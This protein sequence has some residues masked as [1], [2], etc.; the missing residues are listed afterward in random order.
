[1]N[2]SHCRICSGKLFSEPLLHYENMPKAAQFLPDAKSLKNDKGTDLDI[3]QCSGCGLVQLNND[4]VP[5]YK[6]VIRSASF[7]EEMMKFRIQQFTGFIQ[8]YSLKGKKIIEIGCGKGE[9]LSL[10]NQCSMKCF[11]LENYRQ[12][13]IECKN[14]GLTVSQGFIQNDTD[15]LRSSPFDSFYILNFLE[16]LPNPN[17]TLKGIRNN[18]TDDS[19][20]LI[21]VPNFDMILQKNLFS[22]FTA[23]H[24]FY[25]T[26]ETL[27]KTLELNGFDLLE[28]NVVWHD[29]IISAVVKKSKTMYR[30]D[31]RR[32]RYVGK[33]LDLSYFYKYQRKII[34]EID[35]Y[36]G[37]YKK[38][39]IWGAGH[40][41]LTII[42]MLNL[43]SKI[44]YVVDSALFKQN[45]YTPATHIP[46]VSPDI[47]NSDSV[48][49]IIIMAA[50][51]SDE[52]VGTIRQKY[53]RNIKL[54]ILR[55]FGLEEI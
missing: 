24:L 32:N 13:V 26:K 42:S 48:D 54:S 28:S 3:C 36:I 31:E 52:I 37:K 14:K 19:I 6:D 4:P 12:S 43:S 30:S 7:S 23:D 41:A 46:I 2:I 15:K 44:K 11:G 17:K 33:K 22:E 16:H 1:M 29:Y 27:K 51:Y 21:E 9:Y 35:N 5:H 55:D 40:Q 47:I 8:K 38:V 45:K 18:I 10:M 53:D 20:G 50:G 25:F 39:A 49:A 34:T